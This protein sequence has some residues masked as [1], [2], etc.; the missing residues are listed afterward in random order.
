MCAS[1]L[2][3]STLLFKHGPLMVNVWAVNVLNEITPVAVTDAP[4][5]VPV[6]V[7]DEA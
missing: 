1:I 6:V 5:T 7:R 4:L 2:I 3:R